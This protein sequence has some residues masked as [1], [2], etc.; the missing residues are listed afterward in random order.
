MDKALISTGRFC[1]LPLILIIIDRVFY[2]FN[3]VVEGKETT[4]AFHEASNCRL[5]CKRSQFHFESV[6]FLAALLRRNPWWMGQ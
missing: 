5:T 1:I 3:V 2:F 4:K 6:S